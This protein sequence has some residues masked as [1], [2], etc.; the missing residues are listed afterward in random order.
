VIKSDFSQTMPDAPGRVHFVGIGGAGM[1]GIARLFVAA[2]HPVSGSDIR[3]GESVQALRDL[4]VTISL[5]HSAEALG[6]AETVVVTGAIA[7]D[8]PEFVAARAAGI[9]V[10]H[11]A[12]ALAWLARRR[13][14]VAVAGAHG[15]TTSTGMIVEALLA[16]GRDPG[17]VNGGVIRS[18]GVSAEPGSDD[19]FVVEADES[20][21]SFLLY[22]TAVALI[23]NVDPDHLDH[24]GSE[25][26]FADAFV[27]F[28]GAARE[29]VALSSDDPGA[30]AITQR[31]DRDSVITFGQRDD[32][33]VRVHG[34]LS[35]PVVS[36]QI[37]WR[38]TDYPVTLRV[39]GVH[40]ALN[41]AGAF[42][43]LTGLG[44]EPRAVLD[45]LATFGGTERRFEFRG[46]VRGVS[47]YDDFAHHPSEIRAALSAARGAVGTG[48]LI[49]IFQPHLFSRTR[50][51]AQEFADVFE[52]LADH[53]VVVPVYGARQDP[54]PG[55]TGEL[56]TARFGD[57]AVADYLT[58]WT[59]AA[60]RAASLARTGDFVMPM[61]G[62]DIHLIVPRLLEA[63]AVGE[64]ASDDPDPAAS[65]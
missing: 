44:H 24:F 40:N 13:R 7:E 55:V 2:G 20:D 59:D 27:A 57:P 64:R 39:P 26:A 22:D 28:A 31:L 19:T 9:P 15:K 17:F 30:V 23:T 29:F 53:T 16:L 56:I 61:G 21:G 50:M 60:R 58:D 3:D 62:G 34:V 46:E 4:G 37:G 25:E 47:V 63:L 38:G 52:H 45:A 51:L 18:L 33:D 32:A 14:L 36:F 10:V 6:T 65:P 35:G 8:N 48:R 12:V 1:S 42:A 54:E 49:P 43:V 11:R 41:A 5:G